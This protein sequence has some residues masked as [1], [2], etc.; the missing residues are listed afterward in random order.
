LVGVDPEFGLRRLLFRGEHE[1]KTHPEHNC[2]ND[3]SEFFNR[4]LDQAGVLVYEGAIDDRPSPEGDPRTAH[5]FVREAVQK[6][7]A[8][9]QLA[10]SQTKP[11]GCGVKYGS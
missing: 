7:Q 11:Y 3:C 9:Q 8:G 10:V 5:N 2:S 1:L 4:L 6:L